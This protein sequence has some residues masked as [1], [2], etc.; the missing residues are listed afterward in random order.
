MGYKFR[1]K[2]LFSTRKSFKT[3]F[4]RINVSRSG[5]SHSVRTPLGSF[6]KRLI[7]GGSKSAGVSSTEGGCL[8][9]LS[10]GCL[11]F[12]LLSIGVGFIGAML[13]PSRP[14]LANRVEP[15][16][17]TPETVAVPDPLSVVEQPPSL[18]PP[19]PTKVDVTEVELPS[20]TATPQTAP[21]R[22]HLIHQRHYPP[23]R[24]SN[25]AHGPLRS[26]G[27]KS[28]RRLQV[29]TKRMFN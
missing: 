28:W 3:P 4:G 6:N 5:V 20:I 25:P 11:I 13:S 10:G 8:A 19:A 23:N 29:T 16:V 7:G 26:E 2:K 15:V 9:T 21:N 12:V 27:S 18:D 24:S 17:A 14:H 22:L 1:P